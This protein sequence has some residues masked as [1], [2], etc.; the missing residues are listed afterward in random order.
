MTR[1]TDIFPG[2]NRTPVIGIL[3]GLGLEEAAMAA[4]SAIDAGIPLIEVTVDTDTAFDQIKRL[5]DLG[6]TTGAGSVLTANVAARAFSAGAAFILSP[7]VVPAVVQAC[8]EASIP[9]IPGAA[10]PTEINLALNLGAIAVKVFPADLLGGPAYL[11]AIRRPLHDPPLIPTGGIGPDNA[12]D[13]MRAG[14]LAIGIGSSVFARGSNREEL[15]RKISLLI[16]S[17]DRPQ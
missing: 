1:L 13:Y 12:A 10:T 17:L 4:G 15:E 3:R 6:I 11:R 2:L 8:A 5:T 16:D 7:A 9:C 14:A